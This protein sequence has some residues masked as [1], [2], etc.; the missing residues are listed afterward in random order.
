MTTTPA[1]QGFFM[2]GEWAPHSGCWM[3]WPCRRETWPEGA[4]EAACDAYAEVARAISRFEPVT[5]VC[6]P[7]DV[8]ESS[9]ACGPGIRILP[10]PL[11]DSWIRDT[12]PSFV[13]DGKGGLAGI[14]WDFNAW[15]SNYADY[16]PDREVGRLVLEHLGLPRFQAPLVMEGGSFHVD[17]EG[18]LI[19][20]EQ[21]LLNPNR[22]PG[23]G[24][25]EIE[26][27]L[28]DHLGVS[29]V[30]WLGQGYQDD[31]TDGHIDEIALFVRPGVVMA[32]TTDDPGDANFKAF[33]DN[34]DR[35][36]RARDA[37]GRSLEVIEVR[38]PQRR[39]QNGIRLTLSYTNLYIANGGVVMPAFEDPA[40]DEAFRVVRKAFPDREVVQVPALDIVRGGGGIHCITQ[41]QPAALRSSSQP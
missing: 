9:L 38:Q 26:R 1:A 36:K 2:P 27:Q 32:I 29:T 3:A 30:I 33:Q 15:G 10:F 13:V 37:R 18:T 7:S 41:Q 22:N 6:D 4:F 39:D 11:S 35:L 16:G 12:G 8:A 19:T 14:H 20:T 17:G 31:E 40:D 23:L 25:D 5:M 21:C 34:L 24:R 28:K